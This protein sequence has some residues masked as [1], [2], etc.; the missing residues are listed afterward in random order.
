VTDRP[1]EQART[2]LERAREEPGGA[3]EAAHAVLEAAPDPEVAATAHFACGLAHRTL[4]NGAEST[5]HLERAADLATGTPRLL[6]QIL[7]SLAFNYAQAGQHELSNTTINK[8]IALLDGQEA[9]LSRLQQAFLLMMRGE[10][11]EALPSLTAA[12]SGFDEQGADNYLELTLYNRALIYVAFGDYDA[13]IADLERAYAIGTRLEHHVS[14]AD[15]A[16]HLSQVLGWRDDVPGAMR[17]HARSVELRTAAGATSPVAD[18]EHAFILIQARLMREAEEILRSAIPRLEKAGD[19]EAVLVSSRL[20]LVEVLVDKGDYAE[21]LRHVE[22]AR[23]DTPPDGRWRFDIAAADHRV[24]TASGEVSAGLLRS[25]RKTADEMTANGE[26]YAAAVEQLRGVEVALKMGDTVAASSL[27]D[28]AKRYARSGPLWLQIQTWTAIAQVRLAIGNSR[29]AAAAV[30]AGMNRLDV[31]RS[32]IGATDLR[33]HAAAYGAKLARIGIGLAITSGS[34]SR[35]FAWAERRRTRTATGTKDR[36]AEFENALADLRRAMAEVRR[37]E[38]ADIGTAQRRVVAQEA[39]VRQIARERAGR[40][41]ETPTARLQAVQDELGD[42]TLVC[43]VEDGPILHA[44]VIDHNRSHLVALGDARHITGSID[45]LRFAAERIARPSTSPE[46]R[47]AAIDSAIDSTG[48]LRR[49]LIAPLG[50]NPGR[51]VV[52]PSGVLHGVPWGMLFEIPVVV[53][54]SATSWLDATRRTIAG[55][56]PLVVS[57]PDLAHAGDEAAEIA[58]MLKATTATTVDET[59][60]RLAGSSLVHFACHAQPRTDSPL[61]SS[62]VLDDGELT[63]YDIERLPAVPATIVLAA[64]SGAGSVLATGAEVLSIAGSFLSM[65]ARS[66]IAPLFTVSD[67]ATHTV[68]SSLHRSLSDG[69]DPAHALVAAAQSQDPS[70]QF[71][72]RSFVCVGAA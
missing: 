17:W 56:S 42:R 65:G 41:I 11:R 21:A 7:R 20:L 48:M 34:A 53:A 70:V 54:P 16:L 62:L 67:A 64:C 19:N 9:D 43:F 47:L 72:A 49:H 69:L 35:A 40:A 59:I 6:G 46:S 32:G 3:L 28:A 39:M 63:L 66:V 10:H 51:V 60:S 12:V 14:A 29:G 23:A 44:I 26:L 24:R 18:A 27:L 8:S 58:G 4:A 57:G 30:R 37:A 22:L 25:M 15:A 1:L 13:A 2:A 68:M 33:M 31:Y 36:D 52:I 61:F 5:D 38:P 50:I 45:H 71:T 55:T